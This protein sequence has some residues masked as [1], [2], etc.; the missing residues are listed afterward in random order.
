MKRMTSGALL[1]GLVCIA[2]CGPIR[3]R[4]GGGRKC[5]PP[6]EPSQ[7]DLDVDTGTRTFVIT[8]FHIPSPSVGFDVDGL[9]STEADLSGCYVAD[10]PGGI[11]N[12]LAAIFPTP[13]GPGDGAVDI[14]YPMNEALADDTLRVEVVL[15]RWNGTA[16]D[17]CVDVTL[18]VFERGTALD[19]LTA[20]AELIDATIA[21]VAFEQDLALTPL[22][23]VDSGEV[24]G[25]CDVDCDAVALDLTIR[26]V[27]LRLTFD[28]EMATV[29]SG[30]WQAGTA[31][32]M[33]GGYVRY[34]GGSGN[35]LGLSVRHFVEAI[36]PLMVP[37]VDDL[38]RTH[39]DL[40]GSP[41]LSTCIIA[42]GAPSADAFSMA[43]TMTS[44]TTE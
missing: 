28:A 27:L 8:G 39:L 11:D 35:A 32:S 43:M 16:N 19:P 21:E 14:A 34:L 17:P 30:P 9:V 18:A 7:C 23:S 20:D 6:V 3:G 25:T 10:A 42:D 37:A 29:I 44:A 5:S 4:C 2:A 15:A 12:A 40:D 38:F 13:S 41:Y 31:S 24:V 36:D 22:V 26:S 1:V 33:L